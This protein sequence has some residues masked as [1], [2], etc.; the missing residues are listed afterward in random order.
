MRSLV[1]A[2]AE[3]SPSGWPGRAFA[4]A[5]LGALEPD[6]DFFTFSLSHRPSEFPKAEVDSRVAST[7]HDASEQASAKGFGALSIILDK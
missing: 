1:A 3:G 2:C 4:R 5:R 7:Q 6:A